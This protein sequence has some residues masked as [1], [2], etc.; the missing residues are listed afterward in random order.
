MSNNRNPDRS[1]KDIR[2]DISSY[3]GIYFVHWIAPIK[4]FRRRH[5]DVGGNHFIQNSPDVPNQVIHIVPLL[6]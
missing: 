4:S 6:D 3:P 5:Q 1:D 2:L